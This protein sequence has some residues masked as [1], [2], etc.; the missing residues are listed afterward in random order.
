MGNP[1][2]LLL[3]LAV[4]ASQVDLLSA[5]TVITASDE[6]DISSCP[7]TFYGREATKYKIFATFL[8]FGGQAALGIAIGSAFAAD[9]I[10]LSAKAKT[11][12]M[13]SI[14]FSK[15]VDPIDM[16]VDLSG[17]RLSNAPFILRTAYE[18]PNSDTCS[19]TICNE[20]AVLSSVSSCGAREVCLGSNK[21]AL[22]TLVCTVTGHTVVDF[23]DRDLSVPDRC[24][25]GLMKS[26]ETPAFELFA[27]F[28]ERRREDVALLDYLILS[29]TEPSAKIYLEQGGRV[30]VN[31]QVLTLNATVQTV[32]GVQ[33]SK[34]Q[35][36]VTAYLTSAKATIIFDGDSAY[37]TG[38]FDKVEGLCG[39]STN[40]TKT[41]TTSAEKSLSYSAAK[42]DSTY[43][44]PSDPTID[45]SASTKFCNLLS[46]APFTACHS[47]IAPGPFIKTCTDTLCK[48]PS[49]DGINCQFL[50]AYATS[51]F[52]K[53]NLVLGDWWSKAS[54][55]AP[56]NPCLDLYCSTN[57]FC[58]ETF[59]DTS[60]V[61]RATFASKYKAT[62][63]LGDP[64]V[65]TQDSAAL[66]LAGCLLQEKG[67]DYTALHLNDPTC[68]GHMDSKT[69]M[70]T[71][72][73][74]STDACGVKVTTN[75][76]QVIYKNTIMTRNASVDTVITRG[77]QVEIDFSCFYTQPDLKNVAFLIKDGSVVQQIV[78]GAWNY[79]L[80]MNAYSDAGLTQLVGPTTKIGLN[81]KIW[82][83][84]KTEG[85]D[86]NMVAVVT[87]SCWAT[88]ESSPD[89]VPRY[90][91]I[92]K[93]C[94]NPADKTV[95]I[96]GNGV[97]TSNAFSF[98]MFEFAG[99]SSEIYLHCKLQLCVTQGKSCVPKC[100]GGG[101][102]KRRTA[103]IEYANETPALITMAWTN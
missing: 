67:I 72:S 77:N 96:N 87:D 52:L 12:T 41:T 25:Y 7:I 85:L 74:D 64:T 63:S 31:D 23:F 68:T 78:S 46:Q 9:T 92:T 60:C 75:G 55:S 101:N 70:V 15:N 58:G 62:N 32:N 19:S 57:E 2:A 27:G 54:C 84:L 28:R 73:F 10:S 8:N 103:R 76:S 102:R 81:Q 82:M 14:S 95:N 24:V 17:C 49:V 65:C 4:A 6:G 1:G 40:S 90:E 56:S 34:D 61:C 29:L 18:I 86:D 35:F 22:P 45:C 3:L 11:T 94:K 51:C 44:G 48:Y 88:S 47:H 93:G 5:Q 59:G 38:R 100:G 21:C 79:T 13:A 20:K 66:T 89:S 42:C 30:R 71:F 50:E 43:S 16:F 37:V 26:T 97:G 39:S 83:A 91:L 69:H 36:G 99:K 33:L 53:S 98:N 80:K